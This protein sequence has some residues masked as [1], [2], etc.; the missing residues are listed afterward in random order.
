MTN[1]GAEAEDAGERLTKARETEETAREALRE[2]SQEY[3]R[4]KAEVEA[5]AALL[6]ADKSDDWPPIVDA[7]NVKAGYETALGAALGDDLSA[8]SDAAA[9]VHWGDLPDIKDSPS[10]PE[11]AEPLSRWVKGPKALSRRMAQIGVVSDQSKAAE[12]QPLL[13][14][15][16]RLITRDGGLWRWDGFTAG[17]GAPTAEALRLEQRN[18]LAELR[19]ILEGMSEA[20]TKAEEAHAKAKSEADE[21]QSSERTAREKVNRA[22]G[23]LDHA[24][25]KLSEEIQKVS[26]LNSRIAGLEES[27]QRLSDDLGE[28]EQALGAAQ[29]EW[30]ALP[31]LEEAK[32]TLQMLRE[33]LQRK[34]TTLSAN[35]ERLSGLEREALNRGQRLLS[36]GAEAGSWAK[37]AGE[38]E[39]HLEELGAREKTVS[40]ELALLESVP[41]EIGEKREKLAELIEEAEAKR[42]TAADELA[43][44]ENLQAEADRAYKVV[45]TAVQS[46]RE[47]RVRAQA[48]VEHAC[49]NV[50]QLNHRIMEKL[51]C[52]ADTVLESAGIEPGEELPARDDAEIKLAKLVREREN[53]GPV[54]LR[55]EIEAQELDEQIVGLQDERRD[56]VSAIA[57]LRQGIG[58]LNREGRERLLAAFE[59]VNAHFTELFVRLFGGGRAHLSLTESDDPLEA[60]LEIMASPP[61]KRLQVM[62]LLSGGEQALTALALLFAVFL[63]NPAPICVLDEVD[64]PLDDANVDRLC[65][66]LDEMVATT[67]TRFLMITHHRM[68]M[69]R[70]DRLFGVT[71]AER[72]VSQLVSVDYAAAAKLRETA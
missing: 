71:M 49:E 69:A 18:R 15:G 10:L 68:T 5:L 70:A 12:L 17:A 13:K 7:L 31:P 34:R 55:A 61:G 51:D 67:S 63:T 14:T 58:S 30:N 57:R 50:E 6:E 28:S 1:A 48:Q 43:E 45:E 46:A 60:G 47:D 16:Q 65:T 39:Q 26:A 19:K 29:G 25:R 27:V 66:L 44:A 32:R 11:G 64:A 72:G 37:R 2:Q 3:G 35:Q 52:V 59:A 4:I 38:A 21:A 8:S 24:R 36:I 41:G 22:Y 9:P 33:E 62:S 42:K 40:E 56:L 20:H 23:E 53:I 54:N